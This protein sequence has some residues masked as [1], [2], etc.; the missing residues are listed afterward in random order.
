MNTITDEALDQMRTAV[1][2]LADIRRAAGPFLEW[3]E[4]YGRF[5][6]G[7]QVFPLSEILKL[8]DAL[9]RERLDAQT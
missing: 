5:G 7:I 2:Q 8:R 4:C 1:G 9:L 6:V 3:M